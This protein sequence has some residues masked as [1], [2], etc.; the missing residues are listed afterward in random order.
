[1]KAIFSSLL[2]LWVATILISPTNAQ[3]SSDGT[4]NTNISP[5]DNGFIINNG[6][7]A[8]GNLFHSFKE[9]S[10]PKGSGAFF[11]NAN[12]V[13]NIFSRVTGGNISN[14]DGLIKANGSA[15]LFIINP[16]GLIF[17]EN[18]SFNIG[19]SFYGSTANSI[20][21]PD[22]IEFAASN[23]V[24]PILT[25]NAPIGLKF[26][27]NPGDI[28][29][30]NNTLKL[31]NPGTTFALLGGEVTLNNTKIKPLSGRVEIAG[32]G[33]GETIQLQHSNATWQFD[34][35]D[36][37]NFENIYIGENSEINNSGTSVIMN[38]R[39]DNIIIN[40]S[41]ILNSNINDN[42][43]G[44]ISLTA[45][46]SIQLNQSL[47]ATQSGLS[48]GPDKPIISAKENGGDILMNARVISL[49]NGSII[50]ADNL[51]EGGGGNINIQA[52]ESLEISDVAKIKSSLPSGEIISVLLPS[53]IVVNVDSEATG[54]GGNITITTDKLNITNG[55]RIDSSTKGIGNAGTITINAEDSITISGNSRNFD[56]GLY[57]SSEG[58]NLN[59]GE[60]GSLS[61]NTSQLL[62]EDK[63]LISVEN[64]GQKNAGNINIVSEEITLN[65]NSEIRAN[66]NSGNGGSINIISNNIILQGQSGIFVDAK[67]DGNGGNIAIST[68]TLV[69]FDDSKIIANAEEGRGGNI[70]IE[71]KAL[72]PVDA[73][74]RELIDASSE[75][76]IDGEIT[77]VS[78][79]IDSKI[80]T[81]L[82]EQSPI[83]LEKLI[84]TGCGLN[85]DFT[86]NRFSYLGRGGISPSP[87]TVFTEDMVSE[88]G[89]VEY[90]QQTKKIEPDNIMEDPSIS[91]INHNYNYSSPS[92]FSTE[93]E[94]Y[95]KLQEATTWIVNER[96]NL[97][98]VAQSSN[99]PMLTSKCFH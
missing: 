78:P 5:T 83:S 98:L 71:T 12:D 74:E 16:A 80:K 90:I 69:L 77:I 38:L 28:V 46:N 3:I 4:T 32:V 51:S 2:S 81:N 91:K 53:A 42:K 19:G 57:A 21:F 72:F 64:F 52:Q 85:S 41:R 96:G 87:L 84:Y 44:I 47:L 34:Y 82:Q 66:T 37:T 14:I 27:D 26:G 67:G 36:I 7:R 13:V 11:N 58:Q 75:V 70:F 9:F 61:I 89:T 10:V 76:G 40:S 43:G 15:N 49:Q 68:K 99:T 22:N 95:L 93:R 1:M 20:L 54:S 73:V 63:G 88:L 30:S 31:L 29:S 59:A 35:S 8:G 48:D 45:T 6:D 50:T 94:E 65:S 79:D 18:A 25:I 60:S 86:A 17:G 39:G 62:L 33:A 56:S 23:S 97:E 24:K 92:K 55:G